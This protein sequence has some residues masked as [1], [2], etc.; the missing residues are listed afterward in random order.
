MD[1][2]QRTRISLVELGNTT[3]TE[4]GE[5]IKVLTSVWNFAK[6]DATELK[7]LLEHTKGDLVRLHGVKF[8][9]EDAMM[10]TTVVQDL[11][12]RYLMNHM[13]NTAGVCQYKSHT[14]Y[15]WSK[16]EKDH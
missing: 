8:S 14:K 2:I 3:K 12:K 1:G 15:W 9:R 5:S 16:F 11:P 10:L 6:N 4:F 7:T 13:G